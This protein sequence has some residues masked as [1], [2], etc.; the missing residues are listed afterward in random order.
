MWLFSESKLTAF[1]AP[2]FGLF[3]RFPSYLSTASLD[4]ERRAVEELG[5]MFVRW[6]S[7]LAHSLDKP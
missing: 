2:S 3:S 5:F 6:G 7:P 1:L 4:R